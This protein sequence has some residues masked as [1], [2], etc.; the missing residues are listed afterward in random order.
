MGLGAGSDPTAVSPHPDVPPV[1]PSMR[2]PQRESRHCPRS[3]GG[4]KQKCTIFFHHQ[5]SISAGW[6][7]LIKPLI[8]YILQCSFTTRLNT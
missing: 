4:D 7:G 1:P 2:S 5:V 3:T 6:L 8:Y